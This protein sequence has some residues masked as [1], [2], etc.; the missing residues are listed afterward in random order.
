MIRV[1]QNDEYHDLYV[2]DS[3]NPWL[4]YGYESDDII[5]IDVTT[6]IAVVK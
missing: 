2:R 3:E 4:F 1:L 5:I 6:D